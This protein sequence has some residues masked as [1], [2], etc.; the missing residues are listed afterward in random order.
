MPK[1]IPMH[2]EKRE[3]N[4]WQE[5]LTVE[6][7]KARHGPPLF[8]HRKIWS[9]P[10][11]TASLISGDLCRRASLPR[12]RKKKETEAGERPGDRELRAWRRS[13]EPW[14]GWS[15]VSSFGFWWWLSMKRS[16][17]SFFLF[18]SLCISSSLPFFSGDGRESQG[19]GWRVPDK[20]RVRG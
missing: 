11:R 6:T 3:R 17:L 15:M 13:P 4:E 2:T 5:R 16:I 1:A 8:I 9:V 19:L 7:K 14:M 12:A 18:L 20:I 10:W